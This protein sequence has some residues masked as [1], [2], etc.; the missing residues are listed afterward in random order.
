MSGLETGICLCGRLNFTAPSPLRPVINCNC[1][2]FHMPSG[3][4]M[5]AT[6]AAWNN[7]E[8]KGEAAW[9]CSSAQAWHGFYGVCGRQLFWDGSGKNIVIC[10]VSLNGELGTALAGHTFCA[11]KGEYYQINDGLP[12]AEVDNPALTPQFY[13]RAVVQ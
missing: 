4:F 9:H 1:I 5:A 6:S 8:I 7:G 13:T 2:Q 10:A 3:H 12:Q 11:D